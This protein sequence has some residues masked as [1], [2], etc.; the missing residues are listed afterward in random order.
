MPDPVPTAAPVISN[1]QSVIGYLQ[2]QAFQ[3]QP[4]ATQ[5]PTKWYCSPLAP[6]L[7]FDEDT[8][9]ILGAATMPGVYEFTLHAE[10]AEGLSEPQTFAMGIEASGFA[11]PANV[12]DVVI[13]LASRHVFLAGQDLSAPLDPDEPLFWTK[14]GDH[15]LLN[16]RFVRGGVTADLPLTGLKFAFKEFEPETI[17]AE[18]MAWEKVGAGQN[19]SY[20]VLM[21]VEGDN[22]RGALD[23]YEDARATQFPAVSEFEWTEENPFDIGPD[24][25]RSSSRTFTVM[26]PRDVIPQT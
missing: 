23:S 12:L 1:L 11:Q 7:F 8:G 15:L 19:T 2:W 13:D 18:S 16:V 9:R 3:F 21:H 5:F 20:R 6:G 22:L 24:E 17:I 25:L 14:A 26:L 10:N 4:T